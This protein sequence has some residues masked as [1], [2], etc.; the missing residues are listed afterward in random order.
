MTAE[1]PAEV[2][3]MH[4][5][6]ARQRREIDA[7]PELLFQPNAGAPQPERCATFSPFPAPELGQQLER[8]SMQRQRCQIVAGAELAVH[9]R[10]DGSGPA[11]RLE[12]RE[13]QERRTATGPRALELW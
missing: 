11:R 8:E 6:L 5:R 1:S 4:A 7:A 3:W 10:R 13:R 9:L 12:V 2:R